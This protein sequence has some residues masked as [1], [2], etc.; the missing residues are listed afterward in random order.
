MPA[1]IY[2]SVLGNA[3]QVTAKGKHVAIVSTT[4][5][6]A[7]P[8]EEVA[9]GIALLGALITRFDNIVESQWGFGALVCGGSRT[10]TLPKYTPILNELFDICSIYSS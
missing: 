4:C 6:T 2:I 10:M 8:E 5:E 9:A 1:D 7:K 3:H